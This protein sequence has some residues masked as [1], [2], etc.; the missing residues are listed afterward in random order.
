MAADNSWWPWLKSKYGYTDDQI[1]PYNFQMGALLSNKKSAQQGYITT[2][3][4]MVRKEGMDPNVFLLADHGWNPYSALLVTRQE[5]IDQ[6]PDLVK[7]MTQATLE[8]WYSYY[9][10]E[11]RVTHLSSRR[12]R[13][14]RTRSSRTLWTK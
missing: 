5:T 10:T 6:K 2:E 14:T 3:P 12:R 8:G 1:R 9:Q 4:S 7:R 13:T 11:R